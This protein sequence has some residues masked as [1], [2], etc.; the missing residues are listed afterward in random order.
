MIGLVY[1]LEG[2]LPFLLCFTL[3]L[4]AFFQVQAPGQA[5]GGLIFGGGG[6]GGGDFTE[7][8]LCY[9]FVGLIHGGAYFRNFMVVSARDS[10]MA[11][12]QQFQMRIY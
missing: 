1:S 8:F 6:V 10:N 4:R 7:G 9:E 2:N 3:Y 11:A 5:P 12:Y